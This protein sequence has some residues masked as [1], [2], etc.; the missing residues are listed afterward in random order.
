MLCY[1]D[2]RGD[3]A[4]GIP[5]KYGAFRNPGRRARRE[6]C[7]D[8]PQIRFGMKQDGEAFAGLSLFLSGF[9]LF[10]GSLLEVATMKDGNL[11]GRGLESRLF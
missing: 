4:S 3:G 2:I 8:S 5:V 9:S 6:A 10:R 1:K 11:H 7:G